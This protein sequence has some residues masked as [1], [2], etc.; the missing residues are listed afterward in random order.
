M[1]QNKEQTESMQPDCCN[2]D[3][4]RLQLLLIHNQVDQSSLD[5]LCMGCGSLLTI[6]LNGT[7]PKTKPQQPI[8]KG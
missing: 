7:L 8:K 3:S 5:L 1:K 6:D 2:C 4:K